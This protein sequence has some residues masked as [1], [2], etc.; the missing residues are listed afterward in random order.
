[1]R[2]TDT[3]TGTMQP[4]SHRAHTCTDTQ[5]TCTHGDRTHAFTHPCKFYYTRKTTHSNI[6]VHTISCP[7]SYTHTGTCAHPDTVLVYIHGMHTQALARVRTQT[8]TY[9]LMHTPYSYT[10]IQAH[11]HSHSLSLSLFL[12][13]TGPLIVPWPLRP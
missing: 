11:T 13:L 2:H 9:T 4:R 6:H 7:H 8:A 5:H 10:H 3:H 12:S 1:M